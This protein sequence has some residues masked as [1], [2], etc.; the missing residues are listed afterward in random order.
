MGI[1]FLAE[2]SDNDLN[3][4]IGAGKYKT[5]AVAVDGRE[6]RRFP[7]TAIS[8]RVVL[9]A[10]ELKGD[11]AKT[12]KRPKKPSGLPIHSNRPQWALAF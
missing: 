3:V 7:R 6:K 11:A 1:S 5:E 2:I 12:S 8:S 9:T 4:E 10:N